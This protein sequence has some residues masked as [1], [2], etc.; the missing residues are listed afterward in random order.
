MAETA[1]PGPKSVGTVYKILSLLMEKYYG[2]R[3]QNFMFE[4]RLRADIFRECENALKEDPTFPKTFYMEMANIVGHWFQNAF[5]EIREHEITPMFREIFGIHKS[6]L[7][8]ELT[9]EAVEE[10]MGITNKATE[11]KS[12]Y[13]TRLYICVVRDLE[14]RDSARGK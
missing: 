8:R 2:G 12:K 10:F 6:F 4:D 14:E 5:S 11:K 9:D 13:V 3:F 1:L 7:D